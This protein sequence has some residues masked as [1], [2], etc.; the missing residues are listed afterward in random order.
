MEIV[1]DILTKSKLVSP[2]TSQSERCDFFCDMSQR[3]TRP[4]RVSLV[5]PFCDNEEK[6]SL[7]LRFVVR[8]HKGTLNHF[9]TKKKAFYSRLQI[10]E[11]A[12]TFS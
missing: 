11:R 7:L 2:T 12:D 5:N 3:H 9:M 1:S 10:Y 6:E 4:I 8:G